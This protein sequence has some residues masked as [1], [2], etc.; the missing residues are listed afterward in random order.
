MALRN[1]PNKAAA[2]FGELTLNSRIVQALVNMGFEEPTPI[3]QKTIPISLEGKD[4]IG[5]AQTGT[6]KT[7]AFA[8]PVLEKIDSRRNGVQA[9][10]ITPTRE[11]AIQVAE[12]ISNIGKYCR[13]RALP[14]Y[15]GQSIDRQI[16]ALKQQRVQIVIGTPGRL[17]DHLRRGTL[18]L[19]QVA[20]VVLDEADEMLDM[21]FIEDIEAILNQ[22]PTTRQTF[23]FSATIPEEILRLSR[24][25]LNSPE[26]ITV[27]RNNLTVPLIEQVYYETRESTKLDALARL[28]DALDISLAIIFCRT[29]RGVD[30]LVASLQVRGYQAAGLHGDLSQYQRNHVMRQFKAGQV[31]F[32]VATDVAARGLDIENVSHVINFDVPQDPEFYVHRIGRT[33]RAGKTGMAISLVSPRDFRQLRLIEKITKSR[34]K[35]E[36]LPGLADLTERR[37]E[38]IK[39]QL[40]R[41]IEDSNLAYYRSVVDPLVDEYDPI[42]IA[43][44]ALKL[45]YDLETGDDI[46]K[47]ESSP[48]YYDTGAGP[49][50]VRLFMTLGRKDN[51]SP[52]ELVRVLSEETGIPEHMV[53]DVR[54]YEKFTFTEVPEEWANCVIGSLNK[55]SIKGRRICVEPARGRNN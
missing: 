44:A 33:G 42:D 25:Y 14:I 5:Q 19:E 36:H 41:V 12:E 22:T 23:L 34:V 49:G 54:I 15:G 17:L 1:T 43:A 31:E 30:E 4:I 27:S 20:T 13:I 40:I 6:G 16:K 46:E 45:G 11:L 21:G 51:I 28:L 9:L 55:Q 53:G 37:K 47:T 38:M 3:Q 10:I 18:R 35:R 7:A 24:K 52:G 32:L 8:I 50:M 48:A 26:F 39:S 29:K 2:K